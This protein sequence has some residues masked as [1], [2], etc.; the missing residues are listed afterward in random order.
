MTMER[1]VGRFLPYVLTF[2]IGP[3]VIA[4]RVH[5]RIGDRLTDG[6]TSELLEG[7]R[8]LVVGTG[9]VKTANREGRHGLRNVAK[10]TSRPAGSRSTR[11]SIHCEVTHGSSGW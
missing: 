9:L 2:I 8:I 11:T 1:L 4:A 3:G 6:A 10:N 7:S 5:T